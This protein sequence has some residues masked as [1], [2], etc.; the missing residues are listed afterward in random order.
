V[1]ELLILPAVLYLIAAGGGWRRVIG[2]SAAL[3]V[4]FALPILG[5]SSVSYV[6]THH[7]WLARGQ[8]SIGRMAA[9][10]DCATLKLPPDVRPICPTPSEQANG[11]DWLEH[12]RHSPLYATPVPPGTTRPKMLAALSTAVKTQQPMRVVVSILRDSVRLF[13]PT[14]APVRSV[15]PISRWQ[16]QTSY[17][18]YPPWINV[19][20]GQAIIVGVQ[21]RAF[22]H[23]RL[24]TLN[25]AYGGTAQVDRPLASFLRS[26]QLDGGYT[27]GPLLALFLLAGLAGSV[28]ALRRRGRGS[29]SHR[30][31]LAS[32]LFTVTVVAIL[33]LPDI[34][35]FSWR[36]QLPAVIIL[37]PAGVLG[38]AAV[39][40][41]PKP[42][43]QSGSGNQSGNEP[44]AGREPAA[45]A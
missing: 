45:S 15:T 7:F 25:P 33:L 5:Y 23:F 26:Y 20:P 34:L 30:F 10:A 28:L 24:F 39:L 16:F 37:P 6:R 40:S 19:G 12:N 8:S 29:R 13:A 41:R 1:G 4:A 35:E 43:S 3:A 21:P 42:G 27:P 9:S 38:L 32:L 11:P 44:A 22:G 31:A 14:R 18:T 36:Y 2:R 17:P